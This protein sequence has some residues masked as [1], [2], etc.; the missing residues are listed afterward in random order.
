MFA[1]EIQVINHKNYKTREE[2][3]AALHESLLAGG[4]EIVC[5]AGFMRILTG[6]TV[7][8]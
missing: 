6:M 7:L 1:C 8:Y 3:D 5:L 2:F 4:I